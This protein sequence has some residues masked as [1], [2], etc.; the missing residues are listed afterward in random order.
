[1]PGGQ[2]EPL[3]LVVG[4]VLRPHGIRGELRMDI[5]TDYPE[6]LVPGRMVYLGEEHRPFEIEAVRKHQGLLLL[7]L[8]Q[9]NDRTMAESFYNAFVYVR[10]TDAVP[11]EEGEYYHFQLI[12]MRV[13]TESGEYLGE[14]TEVLDAQGA[15]D[16]YVVQGPRGEI[17]IPGIQDVVR[18][19]DVA[20]RRMVIVPVPGLLGDEE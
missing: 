5:M 17:L 15:N 9:C 11:L 12:G 19:L 20:A 1:M 4:K 8:K 7:K 10:L 16:V 6:R 2:P 18:V 14:I 3:Y 13:E